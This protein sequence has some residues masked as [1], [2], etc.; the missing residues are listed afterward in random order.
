MT[1]EELVGRWRRT[2]PVELRQGQVVMMGVKLG[3]GRRRVQMWLAHGAP[4]FKRPG[5]VQWSYGRDRVIPGLLDMAGLL[6]KD[7]P[8]CERP[9][10][11]G[12]LTGPE[13][14]PGSTSIDE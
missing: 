8:A 14:D 11:A 9:K 1:V 6:K 12:C 2:L 3:L 7:G 10:G 13:G 5:Y 4:R